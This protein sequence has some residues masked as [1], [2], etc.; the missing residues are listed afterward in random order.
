MRIEGSSTPTSRQEPPA[1]SSAGSSPMYCQ[2][3]SIASGTTACSPAAIAPRRSPGRVSSW[4]DRA[5]RLSSLQAGVFL[6]G[7]RPA[8]LVPAHTGGRHCSQP[9]T[10]PKKISSW[11]L[12]RSQSAPPAGPTTRLPRP[13]A[14]PPFPSPPPNLA[15]GPV[16]ASSLPRVPSLEA[17]GRRPQCQP[18][19][20]NGA[21]IRN[22]SQQLTSGRSSPVGVSQISLSPI[23]IGVSADR[24][25]NR[26]MAWEIDQRPRNPPWRCGIG[27][28]T[29]L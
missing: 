16:P 5:P 9:S 3:A 6:A 20:R 29:P 7:H 18:H 12:Q 13:R 15:R 22:P 14:L 17:F 23:L 19:R 26:G 27:D 25:F 21:V 10:H 1:S 28:L 11:V 4:A 24:H 8:T 2:P